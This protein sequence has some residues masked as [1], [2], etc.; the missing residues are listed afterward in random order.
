MKYFSNLN[1]KLKAALVITLV[2]ALLI[3]VAV[4]VGY[5]MQAPASDPL[6]VNDPSPAPSTSPD[7]TQPPV[8]ATMTKVTLSAYTVTVGQSVTASTTISDATA[9][10]PVT[11]WASD[12]TN[13]G[14]ADTNAAGTASIT[15][16]IGAVWT[17]TFYATATHP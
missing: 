5:N 15:F 14:T 16:S 12:G 7:P 10:V 3:G 13:M 8:H 4:A 9:N 17:G 11:F 6:T 2:S 1:P